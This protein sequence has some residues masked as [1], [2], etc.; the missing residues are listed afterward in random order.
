MAFLV[1]ERLWEV[2]PAIHAIVPYFPYVDLLSSRLPL[3]FQRFLFH[4]NPFTQSWNL[5]LMK[6]WK[7]S[8]QPK[9]SFV[10]TCS[11]VWFW[12]PLFFQDAKKRIQNIYF[13]FF[14]TIHIYIFCMRLQTYFD[15]G[16]YYSTFVLA[17]FSIQQDDVYINDGD[18][19]IDGICFA[20]LPWSQAWTAWKDKKKTS[21]SK[22]SNG[23]KWSNL[24]E[25]KWTRIKGAAICSIQIYIHFFII[26]RWR[27]ELGDVF[28]TSHLGWGDVLADFLCHL[29]LIEILG[30]PLGTWFVQPLL[31]SR[32]ASFNLWIV[33]KHAGYVD[34]KIECDS[35]GDTWNVQ[36]PPTGADSFLASM[37]DA[38]THTHVVNL[39]GVWFAFV[40]L[41]RTFA[42]H[43][44]IY[45]YTCY[46]SLGQW[47]AHTTCASW[48]L[49]KKLSKRWPW[50]ARSCQKA[51]GSRA[52]SQG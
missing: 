46:T 32:F 16:I 31:Q 14:Q 37:S 33:K 15:D 22:D 12:S 28:S 23:I 13:I 21:R 4:K 5:T 26:S 34:M 9:Q 2:M 48:E 51:A 36:F 8:K 39:V 50:R 1:G 42:L 29:R 3:A 10:K 52:S 25:G 18:Y 27:S 17:A 19:E 6:S 47:E 44:Y 49:A 7:T 40:L 20:H 24:D 11:E 45:I 38:H 30:V 35:H 43:I 41:C